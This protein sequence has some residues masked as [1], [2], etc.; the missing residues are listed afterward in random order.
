MRDATRTRFEDLALTEAMHDRVV[1]AV[2]ALQV[3]VGVFGGQPLGPGAPLTTT[4]WE[5]A[6]I[7]NALRYLLY[8]E[9]RLA[10]GQVV[11][12][13]VVAPAAEKSFPDRPPEEYMAEWP[14][15]ADA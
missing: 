5:P 14:E 9:L 15:W 2:I 7:S 3:H 10:P 1:D 4:H 13:R 11:D 6:V 12:L 8:D